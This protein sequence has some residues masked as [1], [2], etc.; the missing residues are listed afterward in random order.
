M[1]RGVDGVFEQY[2][3]RKPSSQAS[4]LTFYVSV[5]LKCQVQAHAVTGLKNP[6]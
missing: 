1:Q 4:S 6:D 5:Q 2:G 3:E